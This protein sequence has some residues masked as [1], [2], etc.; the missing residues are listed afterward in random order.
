MFYTS[1]LL[2]HNIIRKVADKSGQ[3]LAIAVHLDKR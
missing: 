1:A 2:H 3:D